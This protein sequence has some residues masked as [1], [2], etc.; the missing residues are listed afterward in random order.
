MSIAIRNEQACDEEAIARVINAAFENVENSDQSEAQ[1]VNS[2]R[3]HGALSLSRVAL[4]DNEIVGHVAISP[5]TLSD[6]SAGWYGLGPL[7]VLPR[8]QG[9]GIGSALVV[10]AL[11]HL[12]GI[13]AAGCVLLGD[14]DYYKRFGFQPDTS[15]TLA[16]F[17][18][19][20]FLTLSFDAN[21]PAA[22]VLYH[23]AFGLE[24]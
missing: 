1:I 10:S 11:D 3:D 23:R 16:G 20:F 6:G 19:G 24:N 9:T 14:P 4:L 8:Y 5:V 7:A 2:L 12:R 15:L 21:L 18:P 17:P 22:G 13:G